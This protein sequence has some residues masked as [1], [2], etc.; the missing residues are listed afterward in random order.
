MSSTDNITNLLHNVSLNDPIRNH[1][2]PA[3]PPKSFLHSMNEKLAQRPRK[4]RPRTKGSHVQWKSRTVAVIDPS[5]YYVVDDQRDFLGVYSTTATATNA[6]RLAGAFEGRLASW[7]ED[8][9]MGGVGVRI[10]PQKLSDDR[11]SVQNARKEELENNI[12]KRETENE[13]PVETPNDLEFSQHNTKPLD[14]SQDDE[15]S[16]QDQTTTP[17]NPPVNADTTAKETIPPNVALNTTTK[18]SIKSVYVALDHSLCLGLFTEKSMAWEA[19]MKH[20]TQMTYSVDLRHARQWVDKD[21]MPYLEGMIGGSGRHCWHVRPCVVDEM[22]KR[23]QRG[24]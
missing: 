15:S 1:P 24:S 11:S 3:S 13:L 8:G 22:P 10:L 4:Q 2:E 23:R 16:Q 12:E 14:L 20:K 9:L 17:G 5:L 6:A 7:V 18:S 21:G 19:C